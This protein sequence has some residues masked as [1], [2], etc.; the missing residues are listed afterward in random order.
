MKSSVFRTIK[1]LIF[2]NI[3]LIP[4]VV[5]TQ[6]ITIRFVIGLFIGFSFIALLSFTSKMQNLYEKDD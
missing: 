3:F 6:N 4:F 5:T 1:L 2:G